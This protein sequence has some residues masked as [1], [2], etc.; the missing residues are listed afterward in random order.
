MGKFS[1]GISFG[2]YIL[3][4]S[5]GD[6]GIG[7][8]Y[9]ARHKV[10][11]HLVAVKV[12]EYFPQDEV[13]KIAFLHSANYL[14]QLNHPNIVRLYDYGFQH[15]RAYMVME[16]IEGQTLAKLIPNTL[17]EDWTQRA[18][19][20]FLQILSAMR[21]AHNCTYLDSSGREVEG[22]LHG[23][24]KPQN[25]LITQDDVV[26]ITDFMS[27]D[28]QAFL[29]KEQIP[30]SEIREIMS[31]LIISHQIAIEARMMFLSS[32]SFGTPGY[33]PN[34]Q[35]NGQVTQQSDI[36]ALGAT[37]YEMLTNRSPIYLVFDNLRPKQVNPFVPQ[38][39]DSLII[40]AMSEDPINR[41]AT[42]A[43]MES[44]FHGNLKKE[45]LFTNLSIKEWI[46]GDK[47]D[48]KTGKISGG[49]G[50]I[51]IGKFNNAIAT[52]NN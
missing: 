31:S 43:E 30:F 44:V 38:W 14:S 13:V 26:K 18:I 47:I 25:I 27:P 42:I 39:I 2:N 41:Y 1:K 28:V 17:T 8:V 6:G 9:K 37:L 11:N 35:W 36:F 24:I 16:L 5:I 52:L 46:M 45:N 32:L 3:D 20:L 50:Q 49:D 29:G 51:F 21:Y 34:E 23:D 22:I 19:K 12:H 10:L 40:K 48:I 7:T 15:E 33:M 4:E